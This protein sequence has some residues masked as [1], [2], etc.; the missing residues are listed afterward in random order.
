MSSFCILSSHFWEV[1]FVSAIGEERS[2]SESTAAGSRGLSKPK[3]AQQQGCL[4]GALSLASAGMRAVS[5]NSELWM[6]AGG[7]S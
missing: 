1:L 7:F 4:R 6:E 3:G 5:G 2:C